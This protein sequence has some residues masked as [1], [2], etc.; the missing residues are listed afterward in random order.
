MRILWAWCLTLWDMATHWLRPL[1]V[2]EAG[3]DCPC[4]PT[5]HRSTHD[6]T[7]VTLEEAMQ[8]HA[9]GEPIII[10]HYEPSEEKHPWP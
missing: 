6:R 3:W 4:G 9:R 1:P 7:R 8:R 10:V 5:F 2:H